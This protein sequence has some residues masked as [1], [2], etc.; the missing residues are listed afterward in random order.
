MKRKHTTLHAVNTALQVAA[1]LSLAHRL[2]PRRAARLAV[3][4]AS[5]ML[6]QR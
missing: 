3:V 2:G 4:T 6:K 1:L 5:A